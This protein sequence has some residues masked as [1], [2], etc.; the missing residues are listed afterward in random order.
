MAT[1]PADAWSDPSPAPRLGIERIEAGGTQRRWVKAGPPHSRQSSSVSGGPDDEQIMGATALMPRDLRMASI[2]SAFAEGADGAHPGGAG[3]TGESIDIDGAQQLLGPQLTCVG[4]GA[5]RTLLGVPAF[6]GGRSERVVELSLGSGVP[7]C[8][9]QSAPA[10]RW[11]Q[12]NVSAVAAGRGEG[13][14][15]PVANKR[16]SLELSDFVRRAAPR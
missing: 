7:G 10:W 8:G 11:T 13:A 12:H 4:A 1:R 2:T 9:P 16:L 5:R 6:N 3:R 15:V 14:E